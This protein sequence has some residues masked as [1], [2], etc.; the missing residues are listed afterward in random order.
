MIV[1]EEMQD[2]G[3]KEAERGGCGEGLD[4]LEREQR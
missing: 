1:T 3:G 4:N 2:D